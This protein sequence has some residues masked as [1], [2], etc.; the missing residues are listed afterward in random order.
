MFMAGIMVLM[1][2]YTT[3][4]KQ[5]IATLALLVLIAVIDFAF[6]SA[7]LLKFTEGGWFPILAAVIIFAIM[8]TWHEGRRALNWTIASEQVNT[9]EF[10]KTLADSPPQRVAGT[11][12]YLASEASGIPRAMTQSLKFYR[13]LHERNILLT[14]VNADVPRVDP[15]ESIEIENLG[16]GIQRV[17]VRNGFMQRPNVIAALKA[18]DDHGIEYK[19]T[20]T[21]Y[22]VGRDTPLITQRSGI[23]LW[24][25]RLFAFMSRN[26]QMAPA[27]FGIPAHRTLEIGAQTAL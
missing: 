9:R 23:S 3:Q 25:K 26:S 24:R 18:A 20:E 27:Y 15:E 8:T 5:R 21:I 22:V 11:A 10:L 7:N 19:P 17:V 1:L 12:V 2:A 13:A 16:P 14:F 6:F 4:K